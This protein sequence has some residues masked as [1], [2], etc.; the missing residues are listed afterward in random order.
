MTA[1]ALPADE[2]EVEVV[3]VVVWCGGRGGEAY[4]LGQSLTSAS[5]PWESFGTDVIPR[6][7][8]TLFPPVL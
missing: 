8:T 2:V 6:I 5:G 4:T 7:D 3:V 1:G